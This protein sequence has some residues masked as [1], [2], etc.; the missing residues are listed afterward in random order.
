MVSANQSIKKEGRKERKR[1]KREK[2]RKKR[3]LVTLKPANQESLCVCLP[4]SHPLTGLAKGS[5]A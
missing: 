5:V 1:K 3:H 4:P 2:E